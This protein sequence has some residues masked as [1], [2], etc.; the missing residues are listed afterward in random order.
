MARILV[1]DDARNIR[2]T[3]A[4]TLQS[5]GHEVEE[6][7]D[8]VQGLELF[9][10]GRAWDLT[11][12]DQRMPGREG[13]QVIVEARRRDPQARL[14]MMTAF[15]TAPLAGQVMEAGAVDF[16]RKPFPTDTLR[17]AVENALARPRQN[18]VGFSAPVREART[19]GIVHA[20]NGFELWSAAPLFSTLPEGIEISR[21]FFVR[22]GRGQSQPCLVVV[23]P[24]VHDQVRLE[25]HRDFSKTEFVWDKVC[26]L[27]VFDVLFECRQFPPALLPVVELSPGQLFAIR[28]L[29]GMKPFLDY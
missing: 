10:D 1:I 25:T 24:H 21:S 6:A 15:A 22:D 12:V 7:G 23:V 11:L 2:R 17:R 20:A 9:G 28:K 16:L 14:V 29:A 27:A 26:E 8:G 13:R 19:P 5:A 3:V 4:L 18:F